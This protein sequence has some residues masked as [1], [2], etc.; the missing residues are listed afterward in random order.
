MTIQQ[1]EE[2]SVNKGKTQSRLSKFVNA[3]WD[4]PER[5]IAIVAIIGSGFIIC[6]IK[7]RGESLKTQ[8]TA[9]E[10][11]SKIY[12]TQAFSMA[13]GQLGSG[14]IINQFGA[15]HSLEKIADD[16]DEYYWPIMQVLMTFCK[17][18][19]SH[20][21]GSRKDFNSRIQEILYVFK[22]R[23]YKN[24]EGKEIEKSFNLSKTYLC[25]YDMR[26]I[27]LSNADLSGTNLSGTNLSGTNLSGADLIRT[28][29]KNTKNVTI[30]QLSK[31]K[32]LYELESGKFSID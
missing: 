24:G 8:A 23:K 31:V 29:L 12:F 30:D 25:L 32:S 13:I 6:E 2:I 28:N 22:R 27:D 7:D 10:I 15:I 21:V 18:H 1:N 16:S 26:G 19:S 9:V 14:G 11:Q 20:D 4:K 3:L 5:L 17:V